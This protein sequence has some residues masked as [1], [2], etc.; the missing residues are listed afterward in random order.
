[1]NKQFLLVILLLNF[2]VLAFGQ[3]K[4]HNP[5]SNDIPTYDGYQNSTSKIDPIPTAPPTPPAPIP[6]DGGIGF[7]VAAGV[8]YGIKELKKKK[9]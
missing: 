3:S 7:L 4:S 1:M 8:G 5:Y 9:K 2:S 6:I